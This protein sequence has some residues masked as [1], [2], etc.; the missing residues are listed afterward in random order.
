LSG[1]GPGPAEINQLH[2]IIRPSGQ[3]GGG[4]GRG[5]YCEAATLTPHILG[6]EVL[7]MRLPTK[8][9]YKANDTHSPTLFWH[10]VLLKNA[11]CILMWE[12]R[13]YLGRSMSC[14]VARSW[15]GGPCEQLVL[16]KLIY[17]SPVQMWE[18]DEEGT[19]TNI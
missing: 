1:P 7:H 15:I 13:Q 8:A 3:A 2:C 9:D 19:N 18:C 17:A 10:S 11:R 6:N 12:R 4:A 5:E 16:Q 14:M